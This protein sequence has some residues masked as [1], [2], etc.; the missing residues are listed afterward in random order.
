[1]M[2]PA[3]IVSVAT[4]SNARSSEVPMPAALPGGDDVEQRVG[5]VEHAVQGRDADALGRLVVALGA[6][7]QAHRV[8]AVDLEGVAVGRTARDDVARQ[9]TTGLQGALRR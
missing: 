5:H 7:G 8:E 6:V 3:W 2:R 9:V 4:R 1:M